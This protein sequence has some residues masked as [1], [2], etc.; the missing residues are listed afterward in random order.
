MNIICNT[1]GISHT[2]TEEIANRFKRTTHLEYYKGKSFKGRAI[3]LLVLPIHTVQVVINPIICTAK[4]IGHLVSAAILIPQTLGFRYPNFE[5][6]WK[7]RNHLSAIVDLSALAIISPVGQ[8]AQVTK[9]AAGII[10]PA[11]YFTGYSHNLEGNTYVISCAIDYPGKHSLKALQQ[12]SNSISK[13]ARNLEVRYLGQ[14]GFDGGGLSRDYISRLFSGVSS[15]LHLQTSVINWEKKHDKTLRHL[16]NCL[17]FFLRDV[18]GDIMENGSS[19]PLGEVMHSAY[20]KGILAFNHSEFQGNFI[21]ISQERQLEILTTIAEEGELEYATN[22]QNFLGWDGRDV[23]SDEARAHLNFIVDAAG[24]WMVDLPHNFENNLEAHLSEVKQKLLSACTD[25]ASGRIKAL[26]TIAKGMSMKETE[27]N[28]LKNLAADQIMNYV[29]GSFSKETLK[30]KIWCD[31]TLR[32]SID[33]WIDRKSEDE[34]KRFLA[35]V[36]GAPVIPTWEIS[37]QFSGG[38]AIVAHSCSR[39]VSI[40]HGVS[41]EAVI[42]VLDEY[43]LEVVSGFERR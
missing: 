17:G 40:P 22:L 13:G 1:F 25:E 20:F 41:P 32:Q 21:Q 39:Y 12:L 28:N 18:R 6:Q 9:A 14:Q 30:Q 16:G 31:E 3:C 19:T 29:Q 43:C 38:D 7:L 2:P 33:Q 36:T 37:L 34:L 42:A 23:H 26:Y 24:A 5:L 15:Q 11:A 8:I 27:W 35:Y 4:A 10:H